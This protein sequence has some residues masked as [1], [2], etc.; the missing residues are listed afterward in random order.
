[1]L[2]TRLVHPSQVEAIT[3]KEGG[4]VRYP[5]TIVYREDA[6]APV[7]IVVYSKVY[8]KSGQSTVGK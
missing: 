5:E 6:I 4:G 2:L 8:V 3:K 1:M 7:A